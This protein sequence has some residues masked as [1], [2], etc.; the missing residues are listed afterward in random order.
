MTAERWGELKTLFGRAVDLEPGERSRF[1]AEATVGDCELER[2][3]RSLIAHNQTAASILEGPILSQDR[4][5]EYLGA[6]IRTFREGEI[7]AGRF[8][9]QGFLG[10]GGMGEVYRAED[11]ELG[12]AVALKTLRPA[13]SSNSALIRQLKQ[14][15]QTARRVTHPNVSRVFDLY[16][17]HVDEGTETRAIAFL[18]MELLEGENLAARIRRQQRLTAAE[19]MPIVEQMAHGLAAAHAAGIIHRDLKSANVLLVPSTSGGTRAVLMDFGLASP[20]AAAQGSE[21]EGLVAGTPA[22]ASPEQL[23][24]TAT[25]A[26][27]IYSFG[28]ILYEMVT[29]EL[30]FPPAATLAEA[31]KQRIAPPP[32]P[33]ARATDLDRRWEAVIVACLQADPAQRPAS[34]DEILRRLH[35]KAATR[36]RALGGIAAAALLGGVGWFATRP[37]PLDMEAVKSFRR[38]QD[39]AQRRNEDGLRNAIAEFE[40]AVRLEPAYRDAWVGIA[41][42]YS[43]MAN[44]NYMPPRTALAA[45]RQAATRASSIGGGSARSLGVLGYII[46]VDV[47]DWRGAEPY[48]VRAVAKDPKDPTIRLWHG[49]HLAK[50]GRF[51]DAFRELRAG[52]DLDPMSFTLNHQLASEYFR[53]RRYA[54]YYEQARYL[55]RL[56]PYE[57]STHLAYARSLEW[58]GR[59]P[60]AL[61]AVEE[62][63][64]YGVSATMLCFRGT[65]EAA[66]GDLE[67]ARRD[68]QEVRAYWESHPF[69]TMLV[70]GLYGRIGDR[71]AAI[72][73]LNE[74]FER[75]DSTIL[76]AKFNPYLDSVRDDPRFRQFLRRISWEQ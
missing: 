71:D 22:Y 40:N 26:S 7:V 74:G 59:Y 19:A 61:A 63:R 66:M 42:A 57:A 53:T 8:R 37:L 20:I 24:G 36:R 50:L 13:L 47:G 6:G 4:I 58:T 44:F 39:F 64:K 73:I 69:Q 3:L 14:E 18:T 12:D 33:A 75:G 48:F 41:D 52:I 9:V 62:A 23:S 70:A 65:I 67:A 46:S 11:L 25:A 10:E 60:E 29:G 2:S 34:A 54:E 51:D 49:A 32:S 76:T 28:V 68:A 31:V 21:G 16:R 35:S 5:I 43:A 45:A 56:Q 55:L 27:D 72:A 15:T 38:G 1:I 17:H 30:P